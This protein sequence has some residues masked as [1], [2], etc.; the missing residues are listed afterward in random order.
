MG[1]PAGGG[2]TTQ[3]FHEVIEHL[4]MMRSPIPRIPHHHAGTVDRD[5]HSLIHGRPHQIL[6]LGFRGFVGVVEISRFGDPPLKNNRVEEMGKL[7]IN[8]VWDWIVI[9][10]GMG[11]PTFGH[12]LAKAGRKVLFI[13]KGADQR[14]NRQKKSGNYMESLI[15]EPAARSAEDYQNT[16]RFHNKI[17]DATRNRWLKPILG[18]GTGGTSALYGMVME[19]FWKED[20][21]PGSWNTNSKSS[22][23]NRWPE[24]GE[25]PANSAKAFSANTN[26]KFKPTM[27]PWPRGRLCLP[28]SF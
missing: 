12:S 18:S 14:V 7:E 11:G 16:G 10:T 1:D 4:K 20:F 8:Q 22:L 5:G 24:R 19:R 2:T 6:R 27:W 26:A 9:G 21:E 17:W 15:P 28:S 3:E 25:R 13:E 23:P